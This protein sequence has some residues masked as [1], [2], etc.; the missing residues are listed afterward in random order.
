VLAVLSNHS[1]YKLFTRQASGSISKHVFITN[2]G[3]QV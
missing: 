1:C 3:N 2:S